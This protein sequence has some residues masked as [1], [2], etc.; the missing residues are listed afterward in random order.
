M[1]SAV[2]PAS[3]RGSRPVAEEVADALTQGTGAASARVPPF[4]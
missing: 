2:V 4:V 1:I 3:R